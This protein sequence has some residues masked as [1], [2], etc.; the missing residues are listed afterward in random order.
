MEHNEEDGMFLRAVQELNELNKIQTDDCSLSSDDNSDAST[1]S[2]AFISDGGSHQNSTSSCTSTIQPSGTSSC[3]DKRKRTD[4]RSNVSKRVS[5]LID[6]QIKH[7]SVSRD[8]VTE[9]SQN[10]TEVVNVKE[11]YIESASEKST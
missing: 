6:D 11:D 1:L 4:Y 3:C 8:Q 9:N 2:N 7:V 10:S 5:W